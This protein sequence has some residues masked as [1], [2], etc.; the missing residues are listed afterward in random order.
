MN[1]MNS[2]FDSDWARWVNLKSFQRVQGDNKA[3]VRMYVWQQV[4]AIVMCLCVWPFWIEQRMLCLFLFISNTY[5]END[6]HSMKLLLKVAINTNK[7]RRLTWDDGW[8]IP[9]FAATGQRKRIFFSKHD[10]CYST[11]T[12]SNTIYG[13]TFDIRLSETEKKTKIV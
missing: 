5:R 1:Q 2:P 3:N 8:C 9:I 4:C 10:A 12:L 11:V 7:K 6:K 13:I